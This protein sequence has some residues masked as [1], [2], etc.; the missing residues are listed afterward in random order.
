MTDPQVHSTPPS[1]ELAPIFVRVHTRVRGAKQ[2]EGKGEFKEKALPP[3]WARFALVLDCETSIDL[4]QDLTFL[5]WRFCELKGGAYVCQQEGVVYADGLPAQSI[6]IIRKFAR[7]EPAEVE[8]GCP[9]EIRVQSRTEFVDGEFWEALKAGVV[10]VCFNAPFDLSRLAVQYKRAQRKNT[11]WSMVLWTYK[12]K[13]DKLKPKLRIKP[14]DSR[15]AFISLAGGDPHN[16]IEYAGRFLDL[17]VLGWALRNRHMALN[18]FLDSFGLEGKLEHEP[19]GTIT[20]EEL[21]YG[22]RD[23]ERT[24][25]LLNAMKKEYDG[26]PLNL[27]PE[28]AMSAASITKA[29]L[30][31]MQIQQP[32]QK[33]AL[34]D[35][36]YGKC[37]QAYFGGRSEIRIRHQEMPIVVCDTTSEYP[38]VASLQGI[39]S[40]L[41]AADLEV[42]DCTAEAQEILDRTDLKSVLKP[43]MWRKFAFFAS[44]RPAGD[45]LPVRALY[46]DSGETNIGVNP[47]TADE[48][49]WYAGPDLVASKLKTGQ[50]QQVVNG[51]KLVPKGLQQGMKTTA[52]GSRTIDPAKDDFFKVVIEERKAIPKNHPHYLLLKIIANALYGV[53]AELNRVDYGKNDAKHLDVF[54]GDHIFDQPTLVVERPGKWQFPPAAAL[55]TAGGRLMLAVLEHIVELRGGSYLLTDTDSIFFVASEKGGLIP[56]PG[57]RERLP[58]RTP[59]VKAIAWTQV[60]EIC[61]MLNRLNPYD[62]SKV[63][64]LLKIEDCNYDGSGNPHQ[65]YGLAISAK[66][67]V[68]YKRNKSQLLIIKPSEHGL[69]IVYVPDERER[70]KPTDCKDLDNAYP[71]WIVE[72]WERLL[73]DHFQRLKNPENVFVTRELWFAKLPAIMR[74]RVTTP[75]VLESLR[76]RDPGAAKPYNFAISPIL[77]ETPP[78][79]ALVAPS[80]KHAERWLTQDY[81]EIHSL[82]KVK[83][84][85][86]FRGK[87]IVP[88]TVAGVL[89]RHFLHPE[90]K[91]LDPEGKPCD[92][93]TRGLLVRRPIRAMKPL[94]FIGKEIERKAQEGEDISM[95]DTAGPLRY[96]AGRTKKTR[97]ADPDMIRRARK[98][99]I[100]Q[101][102]RASGKNQHAVERFLRGERVHPATRVCLEQAVTRLERAL[103]LRQSV[104]TDVS[105]RRG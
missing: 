18:G 85:S 64:D 19:T 100:R 63:R 53:F 39:W 102:M 75:N 30:D 41:T 33:F 4:R 99:S 50:A 2:K 95:I 56:C 37:M 96:H 62:R 92:A 86:S 27:P 68:V 69:G 20:P 8:D 38:T 35:D 3:K 14:K 52:I 16:R 72:A 24:V 7:N 22:R 87:K 91:S 98:F 101:L 61:A 25:A 12:G 1:P 42:V 74:I 104:I 90:H 73:A 34:T 105:R 23:V 70:F 15:A 5:W 88:Q 89:W 13:P 60:H 79:C 94:V 57:G 97:A 31:E 32:A 66:R 82:K 51:F 46:A 67:Y 9:T 28:R 11:G 6:E 58:D 65:L 81:I 93:Y 29:F 78:D 17:S 47:L 45:V 54:S 49:L 26:F 59:A 71:M 77:V 80:G 43:S 84:Y 76:R 48:P 103:W 40:L 83:L 21:E 10:V 44:I 36:V 55:I